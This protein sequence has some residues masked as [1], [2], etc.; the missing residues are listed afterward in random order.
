M[1][2]LAARLQSVTE[3][4]THAFHEFLLRDP[5]GN[6]YKTAFRINPTYRVSTITP[7]VYVTLWHRGY[8]VTTRVRPPHLICVYRVTPTVGSAINV[9]ILEDIGLLFGRQ[10]ILHS[11]LQKWLPLPRACLRLRVCQAFLSRSELAEVNFPLSNWCCQD[12]LWLAHD[13]VPGK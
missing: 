9:L 7:T 13:N 8:L 10:S 1:L 4:I 6:I 5:L 12:W 3:R 2:K 11:L